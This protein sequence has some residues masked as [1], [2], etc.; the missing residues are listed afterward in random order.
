MEQSQSYLH[1]PLSQQDNMKVTRVVTNVQGRNFH[2]KMLTNIRLANYIREDEDTLKMQQIINFSTYP[3]IQMP[4][5]WEGFLL[6]IS[7]E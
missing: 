1:L 7:V 4:S 3:L 2:K 6:N 5:T